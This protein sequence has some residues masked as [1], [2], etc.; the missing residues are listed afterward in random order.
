[1]LLFNKTKC[2]Q[3]LEVERQV[4]PLTIQKGMIF[5]SSTVKNWYP[6]FFE[7]F[8]TDKFHNK[9]NIG[10]VRDF[11]LGD[12][13]QLIPAL[14][15]FKKFY[16]I[17]NVNVY[18]SGDYVK[19]LKALFSDFTFYDHGTLSSETRN[20]FTFNLN[21]LLEKDHST[22]NSENRKHRIDI[23]L[24][25]LGVTDTSKCDWSNRLK[26]FDG[27][28]PMDKKLIGLQLRGSGYMKTLP[29][30]Y[31]KRIASELAKTYTVVLIDQSKDMGFSGEN[32]LD[33]C[34][35]LNPYQVT[36]LL[37]KLNCCITMDSGVLW[38]AHVANCPVLTLLGPT[39]EAERISLHPQYPEKAKSI[40]LSKY[41]NCN[42]CFETREGCKGAGSRVRCMNDFDKDKVLSEILEK[43][44]LIVGD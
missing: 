7:E 39:R 5:D 3:L 42:P 40:D 31:M 23:Y 24:D 41:V 35:K 44:K 8:H 38:L 37:Q 27:S 12:L 4:F 36:A 32:I 21:G 2:S 18:T 10:I 43:I 9:K 19:V 29:Y 30:E 26:P 28:L 16:N 34:G 14:R 33:L 13:I 11:A 25:T 22:T 20:D 17:S 6:D 15:K 1:M